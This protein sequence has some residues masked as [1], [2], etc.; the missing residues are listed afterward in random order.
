MT[1]R[2]L[3]CLLL[4]SVLL[5]C[6][7]AQPRITILKADGGNVTVDIWIADTPEKRGRG[8]QR[9]TFLP[10]GSGMLFIFR[11]EEKHPVFWMKDTP[12]SLDMVFIDADRVITQIVR[13]AKPN[14][15]E[16]ITAERP[17]QFVLEVPAGF[18]AR[19]AIQ[20]GDHVQFIQCY[21]AASR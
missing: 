6:Q 18:T 14:S 5:S 12:L 15:T 19:N 2:A 8:L 9:S 4:T 7:P 17:A 1:R 11:N 20:P 13:E 16:H 21:P 3:V 10:E